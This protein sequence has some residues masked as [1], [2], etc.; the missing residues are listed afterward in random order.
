M[1]IHPTP[2]PDTPTH[3]SRTLAVQVKTLCSAIPKLFKLQKRSI[4][5]LALAH[6]HKNLALITLD[7][8]ETGSK[9]GAEEIPLVEFVSGAQ[10]AMWKH[11]FPVKWLSMGFPLR[12]IKKSLDLR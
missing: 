7:V 5:D 8:V 3:R 9:I 4:A 1:A 2:W 11:L 12:K 6:A 10:Y